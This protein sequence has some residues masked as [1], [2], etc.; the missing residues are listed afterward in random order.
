[1]VESKRFQN[2]GQKTFIRKKKLKFVK[3]SIT[4]SQFHAL[5]EKAAQPLKESKSTQI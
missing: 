3:R 5:I 4:R 1:M 2:C